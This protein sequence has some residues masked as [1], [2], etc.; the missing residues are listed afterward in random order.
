MNYVIQLGGIIH[1]GNEF[2]KAVIRTTVTFTK[3][4]DQGEQSTK[5]NIEGITDGFFPTEEMEKIITKIVSGV[6]TL[7]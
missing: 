7:K 2:G 6:E 5:I 4:T 3:N 1:S